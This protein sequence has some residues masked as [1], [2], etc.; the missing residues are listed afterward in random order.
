MKKT[1]FKITYFF[2]PENID[3]VEEQRKAM[4]LVNFLIIFSLFSLVYLILCYVT[5]IIIG[6]W[7]NLIMFP[8]ISGQ[9]YAL[10]KNDFNCMYRGKISAKGKGDLDMYFVNAR[11]QNSSVRRTGY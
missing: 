2:L 8:C 9:T 7:T 4:L 5:G 1:S 10:V 3:S 6:V 11:L